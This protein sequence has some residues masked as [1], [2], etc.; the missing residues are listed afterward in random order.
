M[1]IATNQLVTW[2]D[3]TAACLTAMKNVCCNIDSLSSVPT[4]L[5]SGQGQMAVKQV[6]AARTGGGTQEPITYTWYA[7][8]A[9][10]IAQV[11]S[12]TVNSEWT[13]FLSAAGINARS[14]KVCQGKDLALAVGLFQQYLA[15]HVKRVYSRRQVYNTTE[16]QTVFQG[17]K[18]I[19]GTI[20]P[21]YTLSGI[22][23]SSVP[24][25]TNSDIQNIVN[26][27]IFWPDHNWGM[28]DNTG[29]PN[30][31]TCKLS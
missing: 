28:I 17:C 16:S 29:N 22:D 7:N 1:S 21:K 5:R 2:S 13:T 11:S 8:P 23:P 30:V 26:Q 18:Y 31:S 15:A 27:A 25:I 3:F 24:D 14:D 6:T 19:T 12:S 9:N 20:T 4:R 10:L